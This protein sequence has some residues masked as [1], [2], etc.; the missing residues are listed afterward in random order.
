MQTT[1]HLIGIFVEFSTGMQD[2]HDDL[3]S[4][5]LFFGVHS[6]WNTA[7]VVRNGD[8]IIFVDED[9]DVITIASQRFVDGVVYNFVYEV[10]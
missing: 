10:V 1:R 2:G 4:R 5:L 8:G 6:G 9:V 3:K 7:A